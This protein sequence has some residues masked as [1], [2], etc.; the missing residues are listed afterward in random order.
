MN[1]MPPLVLLLLLPILVVPPASAAPPPPGARV[2]SGEQDRADAEAT[3]PS[4]REAS[5]RISALSPADRDE[6]SVALRFLT[7]NCPYTRAAM[8]LPHVVRDALDELPSEALDPAA[9]RG[10]EALRDGLALHVA[11]LDALDVQVTQPGPDDVL[12]GRM[13]A[14]LPDLAS[15]RRADDPVAEMAYSIAQITPIARTMDATTEARLDAYSGRVEAAT[16]VARPC[17]RGPWA[18][19]P[20]HPWTLGVELGGWRGDLQRLATQSADPATR[21]RLGALV[22]LFDAYGEASLASDATPVR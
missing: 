17:P 21:A 3:R 4:I 7:S 22:A 2:A 18:V 9:R 10:L 15:L 6:A 11:T 20:G 5:D 12:Y 19:S 16:G 14:A 13:P 8:L 1:P